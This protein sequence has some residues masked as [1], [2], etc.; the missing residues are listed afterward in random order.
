MDAAPTGST[1]PVTCDPRGPCRLGCPKLAWASLVAFQ[2]VLGLLTLPPPPTL[3]SNPSDR[4]GVKLME[5]SNF[6]FLKTKGSRNT[7]PNR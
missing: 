3:W 1:G 2:K 6:G 5:F 7:L 4:E